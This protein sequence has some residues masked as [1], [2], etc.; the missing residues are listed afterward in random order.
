MKKPVPFMFL[1]RK[2]SFTA[3]KAK[4]WLRA[5]GYPPKVQAGKTF[6]KAKLAPS[7]RFESKSF[8]IAATSTKGVTVMNA[9]PR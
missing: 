3:A 5:H 2:S 8:R 6:L 1:F 7:S 9:R 4:A